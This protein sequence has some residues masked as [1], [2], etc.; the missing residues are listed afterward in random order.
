MRCKIR[1]CI[2]ETSCTQSYGN[3]GLTELVQGGDAPDRGVRIS[4]RLHDGP[5]GQTRVLTALGDWVV[6]NAYLIGDYHGAYINQYG[7]A[8]GG[9]LAVTDH[10]VL[11]PIY[12]GSTTSSNST[13]LLITFESMP[14]CRDVGLLELDNVQRPR[15]PHWQPNRRVLAG[16]QK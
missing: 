9:Y 1:T 14:P 15:A 6:Q 11:Y 12:E 16:R 13:A 2:V 4:Q 5:G 7:I 8:A 10:K 3:S